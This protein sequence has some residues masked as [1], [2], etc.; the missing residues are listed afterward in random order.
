MQDAIGIAAKQCYKDAIQ[1]DGIGYVNNSFYTTFKGLT[2]SKDEDFLWKLTLPQIPMGIGMTEGVNTLIFKDSNNNLSFPVIWLSENQKAYARSMRVIP[3]K[4]MA[5][6]EGIFVYAISTILLNAYTANI[7]I[8]IL[9][10]I[11][12]LNPLF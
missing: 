7:T 3:N 10:L 6:T 11:S 8:M 4:I 1:L 5:Y 9:I 12:Q 2:V